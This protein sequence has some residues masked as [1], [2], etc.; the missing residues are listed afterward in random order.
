M[1][2]L[3]DLR[4]AL[5][6]AMGGGGWRAVPAHHR[7]TVEGPDYGAGLPKRET[8][9]RSVREDDAAL[10]VLLRNHAQALLDLAERGVC[11]T[12][13]EH[14]PGFDSTKPVGQDACSDPYHAAWKALGGKG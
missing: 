6:K 5:A 3:S 4:A 9:A 13:G 7:W 14:E 12:C 11:G 1:T 8:I 2:V 10:I